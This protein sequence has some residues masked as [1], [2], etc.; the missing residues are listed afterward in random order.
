MSFRT[1]TLATALALGPLLTGCANDADSI[2][3]KRQNC[4]DDDIDTGTCA[5][6]VEEWVEERD[7]DDRRE[8]VENCARCIDDRTCAEVLENCIDECF[9]IPS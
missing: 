5:E 3:D 8:R 9:D 2:C 6:R 4:F 7:E 1:L